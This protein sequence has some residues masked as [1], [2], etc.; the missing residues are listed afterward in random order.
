MNGSY[1]DVVMDKS[2]V[3]E[4]VLPSTLIRFSRS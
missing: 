4:G 3:G 1:K 2:Q